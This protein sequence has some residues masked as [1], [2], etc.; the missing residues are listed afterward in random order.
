METLKAFVL[1]RKLG[2]KVWVRKTQ[3]FAQGAKKQAM[4]LM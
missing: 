1:V 2:R 4:G 3:G